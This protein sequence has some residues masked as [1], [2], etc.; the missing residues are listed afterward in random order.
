MFISI[1]YND[2]LGNKFTLL[3]TTSLLKLYIL[4]NGFLVVKNDKIKEKIWRSATQPIPEPFSQVFIILK[5]SVLFVTILP[6]RPLNIQII[7][8]LCGNGKEGVQP[9]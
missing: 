4:P 2:I 5:F 3:A 7:P 1:R 6:D 9:P 8:N